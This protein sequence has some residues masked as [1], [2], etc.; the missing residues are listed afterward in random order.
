MGITVA[1]GLSAIRQ[2]LK[3]TLDGRAMKCCRVQGGCSTAVLS[4]DYAG[5]PQT[6]MRLHDCHTALHAGS[7]TEASPI[8]G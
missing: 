7:F 1:D 2:L 4:K 3:Q 6:K 8:V 5:M